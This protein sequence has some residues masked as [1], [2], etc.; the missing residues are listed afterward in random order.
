[1][2]TKQEIKG[3]VMSF[4]AGEKHDVKDNMIAVESN[5]VTLSV[6][7]TVVCTY[8]SDIFDVSAAAMA[9]ADTVT[10][11]LKLIDEHNEKLGRI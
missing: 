9:I 6:N 2:V 1:M 8:H 7:G 5:G 3:V 11:L 10:A 4:M